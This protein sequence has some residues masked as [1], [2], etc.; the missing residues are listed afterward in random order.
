MEKIWYT[1]AA[2][3]YL[4]IKKLEILSSVTW[5]DLDNIKVK[6]RQ[7]QGDKNHTIS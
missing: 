4:G 3:Y 5:T 6:I 2:E 7:V 1:H